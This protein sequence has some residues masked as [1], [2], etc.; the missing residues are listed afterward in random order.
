MSQLLLAEALRR[1]SG[2][3]VHCLDDQGVMKSRHPVRVLSVKSKSRRGCKAVTEEE[4]QNALPSD[5]RQQQKQPQPTPDASPQIL[6][7]HSDA[8]QQ[9]SLIWAF[10][11][12]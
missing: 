4:Q 2:G 8:F 5:E 10:P 12:P 9:W 1:I 3:A 7:S 6:A 11:K